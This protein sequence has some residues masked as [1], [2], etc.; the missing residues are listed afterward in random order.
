MKIT[1]DLNMKLIAAA[2]LAIVAIWLLIA[3]K[4]GVDEE[5][6][7][8]VESMKRYQDAID[9]EKDARERLAERLEKAS[10]LLHGGP[11]TAGESEAAVKQVESAKQRGVPASDAAL[12][13]AVILAARTELTRDE[14]D[15]LAILV[16][17][18]RDRAETRKA[19]GGEQGD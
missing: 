4:M 7:R 17:L 6:D 18:E 3:T 15:R 16:D 2:A 9:A 1:L 12:E 8:S 13:R 10:A 5:Y 14:M 11:F 19:W